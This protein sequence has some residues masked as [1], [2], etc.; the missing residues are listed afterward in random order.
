[1]RKYILFVFIFSVLI[2]CF[3][4]DFQEDVIQNNP[5]Y[6]DESNNTIKCLGAEDGLIYNIDGKDYEVVYNQSLRLKIANQEDLTCLCTSNVTN[7]SNLFGDFLNFNQNIGNWDVSNVT[8]T[9]YMFVSKPDLTQFNNNDEIIEYLESINSEFNQDI[10][11]WDVSAVLNMEGMF[12][13]AGNF[14]QDISD[15]NTSSTT[16]MSRMFWFA[17]NFNQKLENWDTSNVTTFRGMFSFAKAFNQNIGDW[18][19]SNVTDMT[20]MFRTAESFNRDISGWNTSNVE[21]M[22]S[23]FAEA[24]D[25][26]LALTT[27]IR[28]L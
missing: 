18:D 8:D 3:K 2:G 25:L 14:N 19:T 4:R 26:I 23:M 28:P 9:S 20:A 7:M 6:L 27:G 13:G 12:F 1:M 11:N 16:N 21:S 24:I 22:N 5:I 17:S 10:S 15:W